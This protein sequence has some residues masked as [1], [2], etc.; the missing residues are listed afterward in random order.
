MKLN[1][2]ISTMLLLA[3]FATGCSSLTI[4]K[5]DSAKSYDIAKANYPRNVPYPK[6]SEYIDKKTGEFNDEA[7]SKAYEEW[8]KDRNAQLNQ[9]KD[10]AIGLG[11][12]FNSSTK[13]FLSDTKGENKIFSPLN[14]YMTLAMLAET[15]DANSRNQIL[16]LLDAKDINS[17]RTNAKALWNANYRNDGASANILANSIWLDKSIQFNKETM[18]ILAE[19]YYT[20]SFSGEMGSDAFD[21]ALQAW[22]NEQT[23]G[24]LENQASELKMSPE[25]I[26]ALAS[27]IYFRTKWKN[28][29]LPEDTKNKIFHS[30]NKDIEC[31][32]M[33][34]KQNQNYYKG[35]NFT[36][37]S[38]ALSDDSNMWFIL[39]NSG[40]KPEELVKDNQITEFLQTKDNWNDKKYLSV[41]LS[42]P[43]FDI[44]SN[45]DLISDLKEMG[46]TDVFD[47]KVSNFTPLTTDKKEIYVSKANHATRVK[48]NEEGVEATAYT[49]MMLEVGSAA[50]QNNEIDFTLDRPFIFAITNHD[51]LP[52][53]LGIIN[54]PQGK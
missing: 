19:N 40:L 32:F 8:D 38:L 33:N 27:T 18:D 34:Q 43:K 9:S 20:S 24:L 51:N 46:V 29:F 23:N 14:I 26:I 22:L 48:I 10:Y 52:L 35:K 3:F 11:N 28:E 6:E 36:A 49:V 45:I 21:K 50:V 5:N 25:T 1:K 30:E 15:T 41:N 53:F 12:F 47:S 16:E 7:F 37:V 17:L 39:P 42:I 4:T 44:I 31:S 13:Q 54:Q 2:I